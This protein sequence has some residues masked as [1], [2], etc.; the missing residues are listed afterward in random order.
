LPSGEDTVPTVVSDPPPPVELRALPG[1]AADLR[2]ERRIRRAGA[3]LP[4]GSTGF[5]LRNTFTTLA[6]PLKLLLEHHERYGPVF[7]VRTMHEP[8]VWAISPQANHQILVQDFD[9][10]SWRTGRFRDL[11]PLLGDGMLNIDGGYHRELRK[12]MLPA[13][14]REQVAACA[15]TMVA[16]A[17][18]AA[19]RLETGTTVDVYDWTRRV[20]LRIALR[21][22]LGIDAGNA[23][24][25]PLAHAFEEALGLYGHPFFVQALRGPRTPFARAQAATRELDVFVHEEIRARRASGD[26][27]SGVLAMLLDA[28]DGDGRP[29]PAEAIRDQAVTLLFA[30]HDTTTATLTFLLYELGRTPS[31]RAEVEA[32]LDTVLGGRTPTAADLDGMTL[33]ALERALDETLRR[34]PPAW[35]GPRR[36]T[37]EVVLDGVRVPA[38]IGVHYS[39]WATHHLAE[40]YPDPLAFRPDR[41]LPEAVAGRAKGAYIPFGGGSRMCL[42]KRFGQVELRALAAVL[43]QR[44]RFAPDP[45]DPL[46]ITTTPTLGP[47][48]GLRFRIGSRSAT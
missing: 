47:V 6:D 27:G 48:A 29:L 25:A 46:R 10:F 13:F 7:T 31:A 17:V 11:W 8:I 40:H 5:S 41:F 18:A 22:L 35:V 24:E 23:R 30:G 9:A 34:F 15:D 33:P 3:V 38:G 37:R 1:A 26:H 45:G 43:L 19:E 14:H 36:T 20:A 44:L 42:G 28:T 32:E 16:E 39:S 2:H 4:P 12:V 21:A